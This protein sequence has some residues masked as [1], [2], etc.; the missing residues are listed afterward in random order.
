MRYNNPRRNRFRSNENRFRSSNDK[1]YRGN[2]SLDLRISSINSTSKGFQRKSFSR[3]DLFNG[4]I[5][6]SQG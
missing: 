5:S 2:G 4:G 6:L 1:K 3:N